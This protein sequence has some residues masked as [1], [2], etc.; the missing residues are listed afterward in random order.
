VTEC[1]VRHLFVFLMTLLW[2]GTAHAA[3]YDPDLT[4]RTLVTEHFRIHFHQGLEQVADE[5]SQEVEAIYADVGGELQWRLQ[6]RTDV[7]LIDRT[8]RANGFA[9]SVPYNAITIFVTAPWEDSTL[10]LYEDWGEAIF[11]HELTHVL[12]METHHGIVTA[13]RA[14]WAA[15][16]RPTTSRRGG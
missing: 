5:L 4:W 8:D 2:V 14:S 10:S 12:H 16:P 3:T 9:S 7:V 11:T 6:M 15:S 13:A 1:G